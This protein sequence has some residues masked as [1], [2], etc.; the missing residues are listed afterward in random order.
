M[1]AKG[2]ILALSLWVFF[3]GLI[4]FSSFYPGDTG[5][6]NFGFL[7]SA[8]RGYFVQNGRARVSRVV[9][10]NLEGEIVLYTLGECRLEVIKNYRK[11]RSFYSRDFM[12]SLKVKGKF[13]IGDRID[14][15]LE[16]KNCGVF[17]PFI[18]RKNK[19]GPVFLIVAD[20]MRFDALG[21][22]NPGSRASPEIDRFSKDA[23]VFFW[24]FSSSPWTLP[25]HAVM[26]SG[27]YS[28]HISPDIYHE[29]IPPGVRL[30]PSFLPPGSSVSLNGDVFLSH[31]W[32]FSRG[33]SLYLENHRDP[34][35]RQASFLLFDLGRKF[36]P[37]PGDFLFLHTY[38]IHNKYRPEVSL[39]EKYWERVG[40]KPGLD[41]FN[42]LDFANDLD[43]K[44]V[45]KR[46][47]R[48]IELIY[49]A[50]VYT[51]DRR[52]GEFLRWLKSR[53]IYRRA[54]IILT[55]D[56]GEEFGEHGGWEHGHSLY[57]EL[58]RVPLIVKFPENRFAGRRIKTPVSLADIFP[59][60][61]E[62][63]GRKIPA[64]IDGVS[65]LRTIRGGVGKRRIYSYIEDNSY[66]VTP[67]RAAVVEF[68]WKL[69]M[70][71]E[72]GGR[73]KF[74]LY[75]LEDDPWERENLF[76]RKREIAR[77]LIPLLLKIPFSRKRAG[78]ELP[79]ELR[80]RLRSLG[81]VK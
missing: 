72:P 53:G 14:V 15:K 59:T 6:K 25:S 42:I 41:E 45:S 27:L 8:S 79:E 50:G 39:A 4:F 7:S 77:R 61:L 31:T 51:F 17:G 24:A 18:R 60:V 37:S 34:F 38:Q 40:E 49:R 10:E 66:K 67:G 52:F 55:A 5:E 26:L 46:E 76:G 48:K 74:E 19:K 33:F 63:L 16:G 22:Y 70:T 32:G 29:R 73:R 58:I 21:V 75:N 35:I 20:T 11:V 13:S 68:P 47:R 43:G 65:L 62:I 3:S 30:L 69:I 56:H 80:R 9:L 44:T 36:E 1:E 81:Y 71:R 2:S 28:F 12:G 78:K 57:N 54:T 64:G 23:V